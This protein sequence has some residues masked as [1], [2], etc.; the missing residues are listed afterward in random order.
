MMNVR[1]T[2][3]GSDMDCGLTE[4]YE[5]GHYLKHS[6]C[7]PFLQGYKLAHAWTLADLGYLDEARRYHEAIDEAVRSHIKSSPYLH[8]PLIDQLSA[9]KAHLENASGRKSRYEGKKKKNTRFS[10]LF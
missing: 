2:L 10:Y 7:L 6:G 3:I 1:L 4:I 9:F 5:F 8:Q